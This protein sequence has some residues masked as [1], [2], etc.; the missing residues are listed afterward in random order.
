[1]GMFQRGLLIQLLNF[2]ALLLLFST[3]IWKFA[4]FYLIKSEIACSLDC[5]RQLHALLCGIR[6]ISGFLL[7]QMCH[8]GWQGKHNLQNK[9]QSIFSFHVMPPKV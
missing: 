9:Q 1:M 6:D 7:D 8:K 5:Q 3:F 4:L 2:D